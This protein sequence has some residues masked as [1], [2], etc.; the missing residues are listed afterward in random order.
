[1]RNVTIF[2]FNTESSRFRPDPE[3][4]PPFIRAMRFVADGWRV[5]RAAHDNRE[6]SL[7]VAQNRFP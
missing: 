6:A 4:L 7:R 2:F 3:R 5:F 1:M